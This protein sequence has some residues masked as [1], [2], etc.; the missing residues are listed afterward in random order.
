M[1]LELSVENI[2]VIERA[3]IELGRGFTVLTGETGAGKSLLV[4][5]I[6]LAL[7]DRADQD[8]LRAGAQKGPVQ[9][10]ADVRGNAEALA[11][12]EEAG[13]PLEDGQVYIQREITAEGKNVSRI[14]G[15]AQ[16]VAVVKALGALLV[17]LHGQHDHQALLDPSRHLDYLD[18]W[19]GEPAATLLA[20]INQL[21]S[22]WSRLRTALNAIRQG[23]RDR[24]QRLDLLRYQDKEIGDVA[25]QLGE[26]AEL[27]AQINRLRHSERLAELVMGALAAVADD[28]GAAEE[29]LGSAVQ[30]VSQ[31]NRIDESL[32]TSGLETTLENLRESIHELRAYAEQVAMDPEALEAAASRQDALKRLF[33]KYG[34]SEA[35]VLEFHQKVREELAAL[36]DGEATEE[37]LEA[38]V[39]V[40]A[41]K[42]VEAC[43]KLTALRTQKAKEF[44][45][46]VQSEIRE[47]AMEKANFSLSVIPKEPDTRGADDI[48]FL[49][50][51]NVGE[52]L[53]P[54]SKIA[55]GGEMS[56]VMLALKVILAGKAGVPT[57]IF[58]EIDTGLSG[59]A[60][61]VV[62]R[63]LRDLGKFYQVVSISHL[64]QLAGMADTHFKIE[65]VEKAGRVF[66]EINRLDESERVE[67]VARML[68]GEEIGDMALANA[69]ELLAGRG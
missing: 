44:G 5:A 55:S 9:L 63:K 36:E 21:V 17:D 59:R 40:A 42:V 6:G 38:Q 8:L 62:A 26:S 25:P 48:Q 56:R 51:A 28:D 41:T 66:T 64:P 35:E 24:E 34:E 19:I 16:P 39:D 49:F 11:Y 53:K 4:D 58:D 47:L 54:L 50:S 13:I 12:C 2:A 52:S 3:Q 46:L 68:A 45:Q 15:R 32:S 67:E 29:R 31:A 22:E 27:D 43:A 20:E 1:I 30:M 60:A 57:L 23:M 10:V 18:L 61:A 37:G 65:K 7:G 69:R 14:G 33:R